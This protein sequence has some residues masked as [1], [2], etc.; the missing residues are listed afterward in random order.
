MNI[1]LIFQKT[2]KVH[3]YVIQYVML[4]RGI[5]IIVK[6]LRDMLINTIS[7]LVFSIILQ[8]AIIGCGMMLFERNRHQILLACYVMHILQAVF[9]IV[10]EV[11]M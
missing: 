10:K 7:I 4:H 11:Y 1:A 5:L 2:D 6:N 3:P 9:E 8:V